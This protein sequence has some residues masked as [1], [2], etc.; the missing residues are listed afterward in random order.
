M[1]RSSGRACP[2]EGGVSI[3]GSRRA[4]FT[5]GFLRALPMGKDIHVIT[6]AT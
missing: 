6:P 1:H 4:A 3:R 5:L 2:I